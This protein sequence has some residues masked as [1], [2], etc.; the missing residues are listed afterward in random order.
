MLRPL[1]LFVERDVVPE[2]EL[3]ELDP[4]LT[5]EPLLEELPDVL[6]WPTFVERLVDERC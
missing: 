5:L 4:R 3:L 6:L 1:L 2:L